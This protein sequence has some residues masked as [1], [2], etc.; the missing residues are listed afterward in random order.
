MLLFKSQLPSQNLISSE[1]AHLSR[2]SAEHFLTDT[3]PSAQ[4]G[5]MSELQK[6]TVNRI[7]SSMDLTEI[8]KTITVGN[9]SR[10]WLGDVSYFEVSEGFA[11]MVFP[12]IQLLRANP[13]LWMMNI[14]WTRKLHS[15]EKNTDV[16]SM[17][18][19]NVNIVM[20]KIAYTRIQQ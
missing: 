17:K 13:F 6:E 9:S 2:R 18:A 14:H 3:S 20:D 7:D 16:K 8:S 11:V 19:T 4:N 5:Q 15:Q 12:R 1:N 10:F